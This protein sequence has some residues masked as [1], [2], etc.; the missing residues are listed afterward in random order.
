MSATTSTYKSYSKGLGHA[1]DSE[2]FCVGFFFFFEV[3]IR[4]EVINLTRPLKSPV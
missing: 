3:T 4:P 2:V 1:V